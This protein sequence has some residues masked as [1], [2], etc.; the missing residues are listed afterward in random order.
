MA[1]ICVHDSANPAVH[2]QCATLF[3]HLAMLSPKVSMVSHAV[4]EN[5]SPISLKLKIVTHYIY[6]KI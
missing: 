6:R 5:A 1:A 3:L 2:V 4:F